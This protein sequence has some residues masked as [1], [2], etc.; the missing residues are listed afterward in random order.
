MEE[1]VGTVAKR[2]S[3]LE[4]ERDTFLERGR[5]AAKL[6]IPTLMPEEGHSSSS[7]YA[8]PYQGIGARGVNN[9]ASKLL[10]ALL[11]PNSPFFRLVID[12]FD[13]QEIAGDNR[14]QVEEGL[15]RIE[16]A[17]MSEIESKAIRVPTFEALKLLIV[18]GNALVY[19][20]KEGGMKVFRPDRYVTKRDTMGNL[21]EV[22]TK[23]SLDA[24]MLPDS[25][26]EAVPYS[27]S[28]KKSYDLYTCVKLS[29]KHI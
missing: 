24:L 16:R 28:P 15:A 12:D 2:Y 13:L 29:Y 3:Q 6:T 4:G 10:L 5:E 21:L 22:I 1:E 20:P 14:G 26:K 8:T 17:A 19:L 18:T 23:E 7:I 25:I 9:L 11:P 27:E